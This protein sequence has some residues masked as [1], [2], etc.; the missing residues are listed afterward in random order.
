MIS[1][2]QQRLNCLV[3]L[4][5][6]RYYH[7]YPQESRPRN[8]DQLGAEIVFGERWKS[9]TFL[10][11]AINALLPV[12]L[13]VL[14]VYL[15]MKYTIGII[16]HKKQV[17]SADKLFVSCHHRLYSIGKFAGLVTPDTVWFHT[18]MD[19]FALPESYLTLTVFDY[20]TFSDVWRSMIQSIRSRWYFISHKGY[21]NLM[22]TEKC[23]AWF[24]T[25]IALRKVPADVE[26]FFANQLDRLAVLIDRLPQKN[27]SLVEH[28]VEYLY[29]ESEL[30]RRNNMLIYH[31]DVSFYVLNRTYHFHN[32]TRVYCYSETDIKAFERSIVRCNPQYV[33]IGY[34]FKPSFKPEKKSILII[35]EYYNQY[36]NE[37]KV[38]SLLQGVDIDLYLKGHPGND[39]KLYDELR[40]EYTFI[41][42]PGKN[43]DFPDADIV[44]SYDSTLAHEYESVGSK[45]L[46]YGHFDINNIKDIVFDLLGL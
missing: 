5:Y 14:D 33:V 23:F 34:D 43:K 22:I 20:I 46:Y 38:I 37:K 17:V 24:L 25:D 10:R 2:K 3:S 1:K 13:C 7:L 45:V 18:P 41:F 39:D 26:L 42:I 16:T 6:V 8:L 11:A 44:I 27:K 19:S 28:G 35:S 32:I 29:S 40:E 30:Q 36:D 15:L 31:P 21:D 9:N 12:I 4:V